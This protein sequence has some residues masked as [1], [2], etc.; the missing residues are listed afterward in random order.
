MN[1]ESIN[2]S[3]N[4]SKGKGFTWFVNND[5]T[6]I[7]NATL[8][9]NSFDIVNTVESMDMHYKSISKWFFVNHNIDIKLNPN[10]IINSSNTLFKG[11][12]YTTKKLVDMLTDKEKEKILENNYIDYHVYKIV[13][14]MENREKKI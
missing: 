7:E 14:E 5:N 4:F 1:E 9:I 2:K 13:K 3:N 10:K 12:I 8:M 6:S 11:S